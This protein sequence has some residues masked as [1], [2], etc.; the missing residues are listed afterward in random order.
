MQNKLSNEDVKE[1]LMT[2]SPFLADYE[3]AK[4][5]VYRDYG[6][7]EKELAEFCG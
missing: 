2:Q 4:N 3:R 5:E 7:S 6:T 1:I